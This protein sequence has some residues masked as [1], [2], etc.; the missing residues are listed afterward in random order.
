MKISILLPT[1]DRLELL[2]HAVASVRRLNDP[3]WEI[4]ISDNCSHGDVEGYVASLS[5]ERVRYLRTLSVLSVTDNWNNALDHS[6]GEYIIML[7]D[8]DALLSNYFTRTRQIVADFDSPQVI[9]H[10]ALSYTYPDVI[11][12]EPKG[13]LRSEG[14]ARFLSGAQCPFALPSAQARRL[15]HRTAQFRLTYGVNVQFVTVSRSA[16]EALSGDGGFF[17][18]PFPDVY[19]VNNLFANADSIVVEPHPLV[20]MGVSRHSF[21]FFWINNREDEG[22][23]FLQGADETDIAGQAQARLLPGTNMNDGWLRSVEELY[24]QLDYPADLKPSYRRYRKLQIL[25]VYNGHHLRGTVGPRDLTEIRWLI[26]RHERLLYDAL[27]AILSTLRRLLPASARPRIAGVATMIARQLPWWDPVHDTRHY[28]N[29]SEVVAL[30]TGE[31]DPA[32]WAVQRGS[33]LRG[34]LLRWFFP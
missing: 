12:A 29:I 28:A 17:R 7:G 16:I 11:P 30:V 8:D 23:A 6:T 3:D 26:G 32:H 22:K 4:I 5:D 24:R 25:H 14:Y 34:K 20:V 13:M 27:F 10:N 9:Y 2:R 19:A 31:G 21:G 18:S 1:R 15:A 33:Q